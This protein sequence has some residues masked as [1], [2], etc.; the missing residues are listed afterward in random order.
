MVD[1][2]VRSYTW[3]ICADNRYIVF[4]PLQR[5][6]LSDNNVVGN[7]VAVGS[8][9]QIIQWIFFG[10]TRLDT[11]SQSVQ[12]DMYTDK[13]TMKWMVDGIE[14]KDAFRVRTIQN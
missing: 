7:H 12:L 8:Y 4:V 9:L 11:I 2:I 13:N 10:F 14:I 6:N 5:K 1:A 3:F